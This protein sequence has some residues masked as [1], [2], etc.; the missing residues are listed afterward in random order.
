MKVCRSKNK[1]YMYWL[2]NDCLIYATQLPGGS[3]FHFNRWMNLTEMRVRPQNRRS[4]A[5]SYQALALTERRSTHFPCFQVEESTQERA[6]I[7][8][9]TAEKSFT[10]LAKDDAEKTAWMKAMV[11]SISKA[12]AKAGVDGKGRRLGV[13]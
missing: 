12:K 8:I 6:G 7:D 2:F 1:P 4:L 5:F 10:V 11:D 9:L 13:W 3:G